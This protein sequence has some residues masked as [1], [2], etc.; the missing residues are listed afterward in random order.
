M[1]INQ[2]NNQNNVVKTSLCV[3][4]SNGLERGQQKVLGQQKE[5]L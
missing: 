1:K 4:I 5:I 2:F 3:I